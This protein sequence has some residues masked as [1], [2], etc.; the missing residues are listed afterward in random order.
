MKKKINW[1]QLAL[2]IARLIIATVAGAAGAASE[3]LM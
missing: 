3:I 2:E 1:L